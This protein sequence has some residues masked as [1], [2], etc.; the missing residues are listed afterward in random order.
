M[1]SAL[2]LLAYQSK[3]GDRRFFLK[4]EDVDAVKILESEG[5]SLITAEIPEE[6]TLE[7]ACTNKHDFDI[8]LVEDFL[9]TVPETYPDSRIFIGGQHHTAL[10]NASITK[11]KTVLWFDRHTDMYGEFDNYHLITPLYA[12]VLRNIINEFHPEVFHFGYLITP[13][14]N[15]PFDDSEHIE[16][17]S[18]LETVV[19]EKINFYPNTSFYEGDLKKLH[20][21]I[22]YTLDFK[23]IDNLKNQELMVSID[24]DV[25]L[26]GPSLYPSGIVDFD[27]TVKFLEEISDNNQIKGLDICE[28]NQTS[29]KDV[30]TAAKM[31]KRIITAVNIK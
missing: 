4:N 19:K 12:K 6:L 11:P 7:N 5:V 31:I 1:E 21:L 29:L 25:F 22:N 17:N 20:K 3:G 28:M 13:N 15:S 27:K 24:L 30:T 16:V 26:D 18:I 8:S 9:R 10:V 23:K 14:V 2:F